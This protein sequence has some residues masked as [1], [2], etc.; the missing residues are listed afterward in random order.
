[1]SFLP[2]VGVRMTRRT[3]EE[4]ES[5]RRAAAEAAARDA[6]AF[7]DLRLFVQFVGYPRSGHSLVGALLDAHP[8]AAIAHELN[9]LDFLRKGFGRDEILALVRENLAQFAASGHQWQGY[10]YGVPGASQGRTERL[11]VAGDKK[12]SGAMRR[13][14]EDPA[15]SGLLA[16]TMAVPVR[17]VHVTR[18]PFDMV[19]TRFRRTRARTGDASVEK[20]LALTAGLAQA[21][22][23]LVAR[24][25][26]A[27]VLH[28]RHEDV[29]SDARAA[30]AR[31]A[32]F[33]DLDAPAPWLDACA[34]VVHPSPRRSRDEMPWTAAQRRDLDALIARHAFFAG[35]AFD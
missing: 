5:L 14:D 25:G 9:V 10:A 3:P 6:G 23:R 12:G 7:R 4:I 28:V 16:R 17:F 11:E 1:M 13:L 26:A 8:R 15:L 24:E 32:A 34:A 21:V 35:Y 22:D 33:L 2:V 30:L 18:N 20:L 31:L 27:A 19:A 29:V